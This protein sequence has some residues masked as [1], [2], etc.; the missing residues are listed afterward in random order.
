MNSFPLV[1]E[2]L[3]TLLRFLVG[4]L[5]VRL[6]VCGIDVTG[7]LFV[8]EVAKEPVLHE[9]ADHVLAEMAE[10]S[11]VTVPSS[12]SLALVAQVVVPSLLSPKITEHPNAQF[13]ILSQVHV[14]WPIELMHELTE[15]IQGEKV[16]LHVFVGLFLPLLVDRGF[17]RS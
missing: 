11:M 3:L 2:P 9:S 5:F 13:G 6:V 14:F 8:V 4:V 10:R 1:L 7:F 12:P 16:C 15:L 17:G